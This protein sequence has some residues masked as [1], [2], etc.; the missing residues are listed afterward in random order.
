MTR[1]AFLALTSL[2]LGCATP[3]PVPNKKPP[4]PALE[5]KSDDRSALLE[6]FSH[7]ENELKQ[8]KAT[9]AQLRHTLETTRETL[10]KTKAELADTQRALGRVTTERDQALLRETGLEKERRE[11]LE[12]LAARELA[13]IRREREALETELARLQADDGTSGAPH[14]ER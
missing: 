8:W 4:V 10:D 1:Y 6:R 12:R 5:V 2:A 13:S 9:A 7:R 14:G 11:L 3:E